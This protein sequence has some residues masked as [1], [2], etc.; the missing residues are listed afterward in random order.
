MLRPCSYYRCPLLLV[1]SLLLVVGPGAPSSIHAPTAP[2]VV[3][4]RTQCWLNTC[5]FSLRTAIDQCLGHGS[6][7]SYS[8]SA[9]P[10]RLSS[11]AD[12]FQECLWCGGAHRSPLR[13]G[14]LGAIG[15]KAGEGSRLLLSHVDCP[16][17]HTLGDMKPT[18]K[19][20]GWSWMVNL[21]LGKG[22]LPSSED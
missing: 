10:V 14:S 17:Q 20:V 18:K 7:D 21:L 22:T 19:A 5:F 9:H 13:L 15:P 1:A 2:F 4:K 12:P 16:F 8:Q 11:D 6:V 3:P